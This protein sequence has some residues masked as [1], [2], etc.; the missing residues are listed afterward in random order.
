L[1]VIVDLPGGGLSGG[2]APDLRNI[3]PRERCSRHGAYE[4]F[5]LAWQ[6]LLQYAWEPT[7]RALF[8]PEK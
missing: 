7:L 6:A 3:R 8:T 1:N 2:C 5:L 4:R